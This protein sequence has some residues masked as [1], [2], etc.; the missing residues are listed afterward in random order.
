MLA[1]NQGPEWLGM[2]GDAWDA[3]GDMAAALAGA[4]LAVLLLNR[5]HDRS[6]RRCQ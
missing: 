4:L 1:P 2:Q 6:M 5:W 3:Q